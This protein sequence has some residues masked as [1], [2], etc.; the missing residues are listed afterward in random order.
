MRRRDVLA[1]LVGVGAVG[2][3][4]CS[5]SDSPAETEGEPSR[6]TAS[7]P[8]AASFSFDFEPT[9]ESADEVT[10]VHD[11]GG[12]FSARRG[13]QLLV[14]DDEGGLTEWLAADSDAAVQA[15]DAVTHPLADAVTTVY[16]VWMGPDGSTGRPVARQRLPPTGSF[17]VRRISGPDPVRSGDALTVTALVEN[18][19]DMPARTTAELR[20][21]RTPWASASGAADR[22]ATDRL[23][24]LDPGARATA[25]FE[26]T[27]PELQ[28]AEY[29]YSVHAGS[30]TLRTRTRV[31]PR[32]A[33]N[34]RFGFE[35]DPEASTVV[36][37]HEG[38]D[39]ISTENSASIVVS[40]GGATT[41]W[42]QPESNATIAAGDSVTH[43]YQSPGTVVRVVWTAP[44][45]SSQATL[46][47]RRAPEPESESE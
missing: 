12:T 33:P 7:S 40:G 17:V 37:T 36:V 9:P 13:E 30:D 5:A 18:V 32:D 35:F 42:L 38:G 6:S 46:A 31:V 15:G 2:I 21:D 27:L 29:A 23:P 45:R 11:G 16:V 26:F 3:A 28:P 4:G 44:E 22:V 41:E 43:E 24:R 20:F 10:I 19:G 47:A 34:V 39:T 1:A 25:V 14:V 8:P